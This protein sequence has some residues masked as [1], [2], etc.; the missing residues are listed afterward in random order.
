MKIF[1]LTLAV[2]AA[3]SAQT[4]DR[5]KPPV[6]PEPRPYKLPSVY[7]TKLPNGLTV[8]LA[9]DARLPLVTMRL[10]FP[11]GNKRDPKDLPGL[12][13]TAA[14][15][16]MEGTETRTSQ[17]MAEQLD[18]LGA[19][20]GAGS[21]TDQ[22]TINGSVVSENTAKLLEMISDAARNATFPESELALR[23]QNRKQTLNS[24]HAQSAF[25][26]TE[27]FRKTVFGDHPYAH[28]GPTAESLDKTDRKAL[29]D[30]RDT[31]LVPNN[32]FLILV[33]KLPARA[34]LMKIVTDQFGSW[35]RRDLPEYN[36]AAPPAP[37]KQIILVDRP[38]S[39]QADIQIGKVAGTRH[40]PDY[41]PTMM[42][43]MILGGGPNS[44]LFLDIREKRGFAYDVHTELGSYNDAGT[45][46][47]VTQVR[48][49]VLADAL[50]GVIEHL[51]RI[52]KE[53]VEK[54]ELSD[55]KSFVNGTFLLRMEPQ[56]GLADQL[57]MMKVQ[58]LPANYL[59]TYTTRVNS[60]EPEQIETAAKKHIAPE[61]DAVIVVGD[62]AKIGAA[63]EKTGKFEVIKPK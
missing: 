39:V 29:V 40:D 30:F 46:A 24:Q 51:E 6:S 59:E 45:F 3:L 35:R 9:E 4:F 14:S 47:T 62:A 15:M 31:F 18:A 37:K 50:G 58:N 7:E 1:L 26:A 2:C 56:S 60:V 19:S 41:F 8:L 25:L 20:M 49:E 5:T 12:A 63:L 27:Q 42:G 36:P 22:I 33:G 44:R 17:Q 53:P 52:A 43:T 11:G 55:A 13:E 61:D 10:V 16:L 34:Q 23:K 21:A 32:A 48:N 57:L 54:M 38:G 28:I